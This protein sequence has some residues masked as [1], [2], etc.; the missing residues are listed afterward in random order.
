[1]RASTYRRGEGGERTQLWG[2]LQTGPGEVQA[3]DSASA[4]LLFV[5]SRREM[6][7]AEQTRV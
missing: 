4:S 6:N 3:H 1:M 7:R 5:V 2:V